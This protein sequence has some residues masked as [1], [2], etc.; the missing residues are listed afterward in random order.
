MKRALGFLLAWTWEIIQTL[1][2]L[3]MFLWYAIRGKIVKGKLEHHSS[4]LV[5]PIKSRLM[6]GV[7]LGFFIL[8]STSYP[9]DWN[10]T[11]RHEY[12]HCIQSMILGPLYLFVV[13]ITSATNNIR[14]RYNKEIAIS[15]Y[16]RFPENWADKLGGVQR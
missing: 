15:Y 10:K 3:L 8:L 9:I 12:G 16:Q 14:A 1:L 2:G 4:R 6:P 5:V 7:S 13:G 11:I